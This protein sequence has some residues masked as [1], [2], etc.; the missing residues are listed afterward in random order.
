MKK[1]YIAPLCGTVECDMVHIMAC[2]P[3]TGNIG[4]NKDPYEGELNSKG[5]DFELW[6]NDEQDDSSL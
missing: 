3:E 2:S 1:K 6:E 4:I 5:H